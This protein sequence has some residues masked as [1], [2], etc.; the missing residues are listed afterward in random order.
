L[1]A[2]DLGEINT[3]LDTL[4]LPFCPRILITIFSPASLISGQLLHLCAPTKQNVHKLVVL[5]L[6]AG[7]GAVPMLGFLKRRIV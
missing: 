6:L 2:G 5:D 1:S 3:V 4:L 7:A